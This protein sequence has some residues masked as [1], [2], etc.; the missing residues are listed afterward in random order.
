M[1]GAM[2]VGCALV[3]MTPHLPWFRTL[4]AWVPLFWTVR[5]IAHLGQYALL[6]LAV[7]AGLGV[8]AL[9]Q[10]WGARRGWLALAVA[11]VALVNVE[12]CRAPFTFRRVEPIPPIYAVLRDLPGVVV[13]ELPFWSPRDF[14][15]NAQY[16]V[17]STA[18]WRPMLNGY[19]GMKPR[20]YN[21]AYAAAAEF[22][23]FD[24]VERLYKLGVTY[25]ILHKREWLG[26]RDP[27][28]LDDV[29]RM[30]ALRLVADDGRIAIYR[31]R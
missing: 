24:S 5:V 1:A 8:A 19:S 25:I 16:M 28:L 21:A 4:H 2:A 15:G 6:A 26:L 18:H 20:S 14:F 30:P 23:S 13:A 9:Q 11:L 10:R 31:L 17:N 12:A 3:S 22:P 27:Q 7:M 29:A